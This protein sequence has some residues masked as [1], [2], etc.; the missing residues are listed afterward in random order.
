MIDLVQSNDR[1]FTIGRLDRDTTGA[2]LVT[3]DGQLANN[4]MHPRSQVEKIYFVR[5]KKTL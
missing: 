4:L 3:N 5:T 2:I 1:L